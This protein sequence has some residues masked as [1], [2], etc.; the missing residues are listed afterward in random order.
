MIRDRF[1][2]LLRAWH[3]CDNDATPADDPYYKVRLPM[4]T[5]QQNLLKLMEV[6]PYGSTGESTWNAW[7]R[8]SLTKKTEGKKSQ[9]GFQCLAAA[10][11]YGGLF[12]STL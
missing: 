12:L 1:L 8:T 11:D 5:L 7:V 3:C 4:D 9:K 10:N 6:T 2:Q